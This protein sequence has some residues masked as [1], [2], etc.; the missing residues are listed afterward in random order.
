MGVAA[1]YSHGYLPYLAAK[2]NGEFA[3]PVLFYIIVFVVIMAIGMLVM[4]PKKK[5]SK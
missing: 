3:C 5:N 4:N 2:E 1:L